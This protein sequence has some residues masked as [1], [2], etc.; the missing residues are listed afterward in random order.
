[1]T[2]TGKS[3]LTV[4][5]AA[6][7]TLLLGGALLFL[8]LAGTPVAQAQGVFATVLLTSNGR[9]S[10]TASVSVTAAGSVYLRYRLRGAEEWQSAPM[11][12]ASAPGTV[13][14]DMTGLVANAVYDVEVSSTEDY[15]T[16]VTEES[17]VN[18][19]S[20]SDLDLH[21]D[22]DEPRGIWSDDETVWVAD[23]SDNE[24]YAYHRASGSRAD[25]MD[26]AL[27][28]A[29]N[30][31]P[32]G[33][34]SDGTTMFVVDDGGRKVY[35]YEL[36]DRSRDSGKE[37]ALVDGHD[38]PKGIW[39]D[40]DT[41]WVANDGKGVANGIYAYRRSDGS[42]DRSGD[43]QIDR[44]NNLDPR[45]IWSDGSTM[46][47]VDRKDGRVYAYDSATKLPRPD[48]E[49][50][51]DDGNDVPVGLWGDSAILFVVNDGSLGPRVFAYYI[52]HTE[53]R[54]SGISLAATSLASAT[55]TVWIANPD[56]TQRTVHF[57]YR[58]F[59][60]SAWTDASSQQ[61]ERG[62]LFML[63]GLGGAQ[64]IDAQASFDD[65]FPDGETV[66][67]VRSL[68]PAHQDFLLES[69]HND[70]R[71][72]WSDGNTIWAVNDGDGSD[73]R[74]YA[75]DAGTQIYNQGRSFALDAAN[76]APRGVFADSDTLWVSDRGDRMYAYTITDGPSYGNLDNA[77]GGDL[78]SA[79]YDGRPTGV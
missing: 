14:I 49:I 18:R 43:F 62:A 9:D 44:T 15:I 54:V 65:T 1:M 77:A 64:R 35:A 8:S 45:G 26:F 52:P 71:G 24:I 25:G 17:F 23:D 73:D 53:T 58:S 16:G 76:A 7:A 39:G 74:V 70:V 47:V 60:E 59:V 2:L 68:R 55:A 5:F 31:D 3:S 19:P 22:N 36:S 72:I 33:I 28:A 48:Q 42:R 41:L 57:R 79:D 30:T 63:T 21:G 69:G 50:V 6:L 46:W 29:G 61:G 66:S 38:V 78:N 20:N 51:L 40:A 12:S 4:L 75:Y 56:G 67:A 37:F 10:A 32:R 27:G 11:A 34:W 13:E